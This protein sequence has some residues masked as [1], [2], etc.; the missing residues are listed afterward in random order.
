[1]VYSYSFVTGPLLWLELY[2]VGIAC[3]IGNHGGITFI[4]YTGYIRKF[5]WLLTYRDMISRL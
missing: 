2:A 1:M 3:Y 5:S 4:V